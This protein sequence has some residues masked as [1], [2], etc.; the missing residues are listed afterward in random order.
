MRRAHTI[1][2][3][4]GIGFTILVLFGLAIAYWRIGGLLFNPGK[5]SAQSRRDVTI[6]GFASHAEFEAECERCHTPLHSIQGNLCMECHT[7]IARE[8]DQQNGSHSLFTDVMQCFTCHSDHRGR[9][10]NL[11]LAALEHFDHDLAK[12]SLRW[13]QVDYAAEPIECQHCHSFEDGITTPVENCLNCHGNYDSEFMAMH[14]QTF[15]RACLDCHDGQ[16]RMLAFDHTQTDFPLIGQHSDLSCMEC[17]QNALFADTPSQC[18]GCHSEPQIHAGLFSDDCATCHESESWRT[19]FWNGQS[20]DH[21]TQS[22]FSLEHH[23]VS[24]DGQSMNCQACHF[25]VSDK[26]IGFAAQACSTC[27]QQADP[28]FMSDHQQQFGSECVACHDGTG[29]LANFDHNQF[30]LLDG[31][32]INLDCESCHIDQVY[33][34]L[35]SDC[36][37]CHTEPQIHTGLFGLQ[38]QNCHS[39]QAWVPASL[40]SH[41]FPLDHGKQGLVTCETC[42]PNSYVQYTCYGCHDHQPEKI[43]REHLE[44]GISGT[45]LPDCARCHPNGLEND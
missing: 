5:L 6:Q 16:D 41:S 10:F 3:P 31:G 9:D 32:H 38:C 45:E 34:G 35:A 19:A 30:F 8:I 1:F 24:Y 26:M 43:E 17:H 13:H 42:H 7:D 37:D 18:I 25:A 27:H 15:G 12:F 21:S 23:L 22:G 29:R 28:V 14:Q 39:T 2:S 20:F 4:F 36:A 40:T 44:E 33:R 11:T